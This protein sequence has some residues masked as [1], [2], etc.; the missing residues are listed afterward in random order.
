M[1]TTEMNCPHGV[2]MRLGCAK[3]IRIERRTLAIPTVAMMAVG[4]AWNYEQRRP[5][6]DVGDL[7]AK[8]AW[9]LYEAVCRN[10]E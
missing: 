8:A 7:Y 4:L 3:C 6:E 1:T 2:N 10:V 9:E 5:Q